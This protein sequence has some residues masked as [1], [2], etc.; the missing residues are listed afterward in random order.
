M[1]RHPAELGIAFQTDD[2]VMMTPKRGAACCR[3]VTPRTIM[4][5]L[6]TDA[7]SRLDAGLAFR[8]FGSLSRDERQSARR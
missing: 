2:H 7:S 3:D 5:R 1:Y 6:Q 4:E 8:C